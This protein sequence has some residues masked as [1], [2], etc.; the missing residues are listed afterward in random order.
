MSINNKLFFILLVG[1]FLLYFGLK[2]RV[3]NIATVY[4]PKNILDVVANIADIRAI[5][6]YFMDNTLGNTHDI[7]VFSFQFSCSV[8]MLI[9]HFFI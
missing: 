7:P 4:R 9:S 5:L 2:I 6:F 8:F 3:V 1:N